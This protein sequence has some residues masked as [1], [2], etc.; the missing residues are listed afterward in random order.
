MALFI[1]CFVL[2]YAASVIPLVKDLSEGV[3]TIILTVSVSAVAAFLFP[4]DEEK[5]AEKHG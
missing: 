4:K 3:R 5:G 2:S 1:V